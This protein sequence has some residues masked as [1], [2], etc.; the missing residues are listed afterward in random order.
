MSLAESLSRARAKGRTAFVPFITAG[1][2]SW[3]ATTRFLKALAAAGADIIELGVPFSDPVADGPTIQKASQRALAAGMTLAGVFNGLKKL[4]AEGFTT[5]VILFTYLNPALTFGAESFARHCAASGVNGVLTVDLPV[6]QSDCVAQALRRRGVELVPLAS[7]STS[8]ERLVKI[9]RAADSL[10]Y[11]V[12]RDG[13]TGVRRGLAPGLKRRLEEVRSRTGKPLIVGFGVAGPRQARA[14]AAL[15]E[16]VVVGSALV[17]TIARARSP[18][19]AEKNLTRL[20]RRLIAALEV[21]C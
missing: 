8:I 16:G 2:P 15:A 3:S 9:G 1:D 5:P 6:E 19:A 13:V 4:R 12:S 18:R 17:D 14:L 20:A 7:P 21:S 10:V 11:Y